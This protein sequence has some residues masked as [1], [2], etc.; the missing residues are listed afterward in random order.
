MCPQII[1]SIVNPFLFRNG[2][3][4][5]CTLLQKWLRIDDAQKSRKK[6]HFFKFPNEPTEREAWLKNI[7]R[8]GFTPT[9]FSRVCSLHFANDCIRSASNDPRGRRSKLK[10]VGLNEGAI[11]TI[12]PH[13]PLSKRVTPSFPRS[14]AATSTLRL[15][16]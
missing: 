9:S 5:L 12:F 10:K 2:V 4:V 16:N 14:E 6:I 13:Y 3:Q 15:Q 7:S 8:R 11:P 1:V